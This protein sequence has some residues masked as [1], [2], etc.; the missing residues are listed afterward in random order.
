MALPFLHYF[1]FS[2]HQF[3][4]VRCLAKNGVYSDLG[5]TR[6]HIP[7]LTETSHSTWNHYETTVSIW[8]L[9][10]APEHVCNKECCLRIILQTLPVGRYQSPGVSLGVF[11]KFLLS[12]LLCRLNLRRSFS[13]FKP[14]VI[15]RFR[16]EIFCTLY[17]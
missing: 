15:N 13:V 5:N 8:D 12:M 9:F 10:L 4:I 6:H 7:V 17:L 2:Y 3:I 16:E 14:L 1:D 11:V